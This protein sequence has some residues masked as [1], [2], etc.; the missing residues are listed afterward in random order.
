[1]SMDGFPWLTMLTLLPLLGGLAVV[2][3]GAEQSRVAR[4]LSLVFSF[5]A[6]LMAVLVWRAFDPATGAM[7]FNERYAWVPALNIEYRLG[8]DG[9]G[10]LMVLLTALLVPLS[11]L[12]SRPDMERGH[13]YHALILWLQAGLFG[14]FTAL[15]FF[16]WF[17]FWELSL[18][19]AFFLVKFWGGP[20]RTRAAFQFFIYTMVGS[21][22][23]LLAFLAIFLATGQFDFLTLSGM[24]QTGELNSALVAPGHLGWPDLSG[25][26]LL[27]I[28]FAMA[29]LGFAVKIP[30]FPF[31]TWLP[32]TYAEASSPVTLLLTGVMSKMGV[33]GFLRI[34]LPIFPEPARWVLK[35]LLALTVVSIVFSAFAAFAQTCLVTLPSTTWVTVSWECW[36]SSVQGRG[37]WRARCSARRHW[38]G[39]CCKCSTMASRHPLCFSLSA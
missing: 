19:P 26:A 32:L 20:E 7:Q 21:I 18:I 2:C 17:L 6:L 8:V 34:L 14:T 11:L 4:V 39:C 37:S 13:L 29:F 12:S 30:I 35:P 16:H 23:L 3:L 15:N 5:G 10:L 33:Y 27:L 1:M 25:R 28:L 24:A 22:A 36:S 38:T 31:H 9:L